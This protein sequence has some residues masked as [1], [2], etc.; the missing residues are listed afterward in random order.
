M[1]C[2][3]VLVRLG[4]VCSHFD[5]EVQVGGVCGCFGKVGWGM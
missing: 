4:G 5:M 2:V 3:A 1:G